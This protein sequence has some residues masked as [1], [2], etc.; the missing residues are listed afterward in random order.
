MVSDREE[1][2]MEVMEGRIIE[3]EEEMKMK[4]EVLNEMEENVKEAYNLK[5]ELA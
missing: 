3:L 4:D 2:K 1:W 5:F